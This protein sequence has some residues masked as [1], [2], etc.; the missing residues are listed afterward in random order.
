M[1]QPNAD[2]LDMLEE[3]NDPA[4]QGARAELDR[5]YTVA[6]PAHLSAA[7]DRAVYARMAI[8]SE[9]VRVPA[10]RRDSL[11]VRRRRF[12]T[13]RGRLG[14]L[15]AVLLLALSGGM[16]YLRLNNPAPASAQEIGRAHV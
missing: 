2:Y 6:P 7:M 1:T 8:L 10:P 11:P 3:Q 13:G 12:V 9:A 5:A 16:G 15:V 4:V 14:S